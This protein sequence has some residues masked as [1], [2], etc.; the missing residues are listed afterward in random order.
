MKQTTREFV[1]ILRSVGINL[2]LYAVLLIAAAGLLTACHCYPGATFLER[3][4]AAFYMTRLEA[5]DGSNHHLLIAILVF[6]LP[7]LSVVIL[8]E[9]A[10]RMAT[11]YLGRKQRTQE[12][13]QM[14]ISTLSK[15]TVLC[16]AGELGRALILEMLQR[17]PNADLVIVDTKDD[18]LQELGITS[19]NVRHINGDMTSMQVL[20]SANVQTAASLIL[21]SGNDAFNLE[22][23]YKALRLNPS[24]QIWVRL[25]RRGISEFLDTRSLTNIHFFSPYQQAAESLANSLQDTAK[26]R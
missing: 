19:P 21:T 8:G 24:V 7:L 3:V 26:R 6:L 25:Y 5:V 16:G 17:N 13:E 2:G 14:M 11:L 23:T 1:V 4:V 18:I 20:E 12:W 15:H 9:G 10:F 22:T